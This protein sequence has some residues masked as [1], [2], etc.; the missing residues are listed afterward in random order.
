M[1]IHAFESLSSIRFGHL[2]NHVSIDVA[3]SIC[4][5]ISNNHYSALL[6]L[7]KKKAFDRVNDAIFLQKCYHHGILGTAHKFFQLV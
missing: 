4:D 5:N 7:D 1:A 6:L 2:I 3:S